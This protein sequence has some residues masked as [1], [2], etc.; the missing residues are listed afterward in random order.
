MLKSV[1]VLA[2][3]I[4]KLLFFEVFKPFVELKKGKGLSS[5]WK[6]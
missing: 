3:V 5:E 6:D 4:S 1:T 2:T